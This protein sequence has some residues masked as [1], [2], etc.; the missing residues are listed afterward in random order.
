RL[1][2]ALAVASAVDAALHD[3]LALQGGIPVYELVGAP[4]RPEVPTARTIGIV[5]SAAAALAAR[6][7][8]RAGYAVLK[9][10]LGSADTGEDIARVRAVRAA[11]PDVRL[12]LDPNGAWDAGTATDVLTALSPLGID[13]VEQPVPAG[14]PEDLVRIAQ[15]TGLPI[16]AD[17]DAGTLADVRSLPAGLAGI[18]IKLAEC[19]G[20]DAA[21]QLA[22]TATAAG[23]H[24]MLG[25][26]VASSLGIAPA[27]HLS[28]VARWIDLDGHLLLTDDPWDGLGGHDG[29]L[30]CPDSGGLG[31]RRRH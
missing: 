22:T 27:V 24:V 19:G 29:V 23:M 12:L 6:A 5:E 25:C 1:A 3:L 18:N 28:G 31:V 20:I 16:I 11:A 7:L 4:P 14:S 26:L 8:V 9:L 21:R 17:E 13:A 10:K 30:R 2:D 15:A